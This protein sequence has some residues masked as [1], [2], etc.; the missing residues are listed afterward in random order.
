MSRLLEIQGIECA[1]GDTQMRLSA[2][3]LFHDLSEEQAQAYLG[4]SG[5]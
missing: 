5:A 4:E 1:Y 2:A 3:C